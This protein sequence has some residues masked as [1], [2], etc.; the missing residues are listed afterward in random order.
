MKLST[1]GR[2]GM[3]AIVELA[4][5]P[6]N[7][8]LQMSEI[9]RRHNLS[10][11]YL[12]AMLTSLRQHG[13][14]TSQRGVKGGYR[15]ARAPEEIKVREILTALE[16]DLAITD[17]IADPESCARSGDCETFGIWKSVNDAMVN[18]LDGVSLA[19][20]INN[21]ETGHGPHSE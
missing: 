17:C 16:G 8:P 12:H 4:R 1:K 6:G 21:K 14:V 15:L 13:L 5:S 19:D 3:R 7:E 11:K 2:Y 18:A 9:A 20:V 10:R